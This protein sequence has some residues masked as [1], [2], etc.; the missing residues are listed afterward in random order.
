MTFMRVS[1]DDFTGSNNCPSF[2]N[3]SL[4]QKRA[5]MEKDALELR[6]VAELLFERFG[7]ELDV[8][9]T[10]LCSSVSISPRTDQVSCTLKNLESV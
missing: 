10:A 2:S 7:K 1:A 8:E 3:A 4:P 9:Q 6:E 5:E